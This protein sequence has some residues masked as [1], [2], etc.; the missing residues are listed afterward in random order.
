MFVHIL[1]CTN[2]NGNIVRIYTPSLCNIPPNIPPSTLSDRVNPIADRRRVI[3]LS[4]DSV[5]IERELSAIIPHTSRQSPNGHATPPRSIAIGVG[6]FSPDRC[7]RTR[8]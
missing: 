3:A 6:I 7:E 4:R 1:A 5:V 8:G 2:I